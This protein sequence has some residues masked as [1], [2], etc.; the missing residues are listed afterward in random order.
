[1]RFPSFQVVS[2]DVPNNTLDLSHTICLK[3]NSHV[4]K[5]KRWGIGEHICFHFA[6]GIQRDA[7]TVEC[8][9]FQKN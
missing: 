7:F 2:Q 5:L 6:A 1:M 3:F 8:P 9:M 4:Y